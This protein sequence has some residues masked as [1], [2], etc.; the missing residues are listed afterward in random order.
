M[1]VVQTVYYVMEELPHFN[2][3]IETLVLSLKLT[4]TSI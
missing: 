2:A 4:I 1:I 3:E